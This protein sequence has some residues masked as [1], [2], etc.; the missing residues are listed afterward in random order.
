VYTIV[1]K[2]KDYATIS[3]QRYIVYKE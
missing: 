3:M 1:Y 2:M